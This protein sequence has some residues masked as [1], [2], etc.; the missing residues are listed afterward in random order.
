MNRK[1]GSGTF[2][3]HLSSIVRPSSFHFKS[4]L[5]VRYIDAGGGQDCA[6]ELL[7]AFGPDY[8]LERL[9]VRLVASPRHADV[10]LVSGCVTSKMDDPLR[11]TYEA[12]P[13]PKVVIAFGDA[14]ITG[15]YFLGTNRNI[16]PVSAVIPVHHS[17]VGDPPSASS[18]VEF[19][20]QLTQTRKC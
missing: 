15:G 16:G 19:F 9:G 20:N 4:A 12:R 14:A 7:A 3:P 18:I 13:N 17:I 1:S 2:T 5:N 11:L 8:D 6:N 10:L